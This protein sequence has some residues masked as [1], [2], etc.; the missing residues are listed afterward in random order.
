MSFL[1]RT[2]ST[3]SSK[4][5]MW[6]TA[7]PDSNGDYY[8]GPG[9]FGDDTTGYTFAART[10]HSAKCDYRGVL[11]PPTSNEDENAGWGPGSEI[12]ASNG[13][14]YLCLNAVNPA[15]WIRPAS[16]ALLDGALLNVPGSVSATNLATGAV[17][18]KL[19]AAA[20]PV[21]FNSQ[22]LTL[23]GEPT[24]GTSVA[25]QN[26]VNAAVVR[27]KLQRLM[28][29]NELN[30]ASLL[31]S[32]FLD[33]GDGTGIAAARA[34]A[35]ANPTKQYII[36]IGPG[37]YTLTAS[38]P[39]ITTLDNA[40]FIGAGIGK[41]VIVGTAISGVSGNIFTT[42]AGSYLSDMT[43]TSPA[44]VTGMTTPIGDGLIKVTSNCTFKRLDVT[45]TGHAT[46][47]HPSAI[48][49]AAYLVD[50]P[51]CTFEDITCRSSGFGAGTSAV[52]ELYGIFLF[53]TGAALSVASVPTVISRLTYINDSSGVYAPTA[54]YALMDWLI[55][56]DI[57][58]VRAQGVNWSVVPTGNIR[59]PDIAGVM[60]DARGGAA[61]KQYDAV[62]M[63]I[64]G[65]ATIT[66]M[67]VQATL[68]GDANVNAN[69]LSC[70]IASGNSGGPA[71]ITNARVDVTADCTVAGAGSV[72]VFGERN[73]MTGT[74]IRASLGT[75]GDV[76][77][78]TVSTG[79]SDS[80]DITATMCRNMTFAA[81]ALITNMRVNP[82]R[83]T[84]TLTIGAGAL[85]TYVALSH[86]GTLLDQ[87]TRSTVIVDKGAK[88]PT[89]SV[90]SKLP[91]ILSGQQGDVRIQRTYPGPTAGSLASENT[92][93]PTYETS[94]TAGLGPASTA[95]GFR[96]QGRRF[97]VNGGTSTTS[98]GGIRCT[99]AYMYRGSVAGRGGFYWSTKIVF[100][101]YAANRQLFVG[102]LAATTAFS[103]TTVPSAQVDCLF[104]G[105]DS[106]DTNLQI[107]CNDA[108]GTCAKTDLGSNFLANTTSVLYVS[109]WCEPNGSVM[110]YRVMRVDETGVLAF[111]QGTVSSNLPT[112]TTF[113]TW[114][115][116]QN[117]G[118]TNAQ[119][120]PEWYEQY[121]ETGSV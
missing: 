75:T 71:T 106:A 60:V 1:N 59:G 95:A 7:D 4:F 63:V 64:G 43:I 45:M 37:T 8:P 73:N 9:V 118:G 93:S 100:P 97:Y 101:N 79:F 88:Y 120:F 35:A 113:L 10:N 67:R 77:V 29:G 20:A 27:H 52:G 117:T 23:V 98:Y 57:Q 76:L 17:Q 15:S 12:F 32:G 119:A 18:T 22:E 46:V 3:I 91:T 85:D 108:S 74:T 30:G 50:A 14:L 115:V 21:A 16:A 44:P 107:M 111:A 33:P 78:N 81:S 65:T 25:T 34:Y 51:G 11:D 55:V 96:T 58:T 54:C 99:E 24:A 68:L 53:A 90:G 61:S 102:L 94:S 83:I 114:H 84:G 39:S 110:Y 42:V 28:V 38:N 112:N 5:V 87:G 36:D 86:I 103:D 26:Y 70:M 49:F 116:F 13:K 82:S 92:G 109:F 47:T 41:T 19:A 89:L 80:F 40:R 6:V 66:G 121:S 69:S 104:V 56:R 2:Y 31:D 62:R 48:C 72:K 105:C